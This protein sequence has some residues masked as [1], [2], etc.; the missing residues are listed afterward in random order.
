MKSPKKKYCSYSLKEKD[1]RNTKEFND[2]FDEKK[3]DFI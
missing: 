2:N 3:L 1:S